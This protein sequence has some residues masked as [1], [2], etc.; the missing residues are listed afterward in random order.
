[1]KKYLKWIICFISLI[2][3]I[4]LGIF[5]LTKND[6]YID[7]IVYNFI[8]RYISDDLTSIIKI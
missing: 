1:M 4:I 7:S 8:S 6:I 3:F 2:I 5:V